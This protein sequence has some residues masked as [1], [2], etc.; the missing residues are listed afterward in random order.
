M[1]VKSEAGIKIHIVN[2]PLLGT[3]SAPLSVCLEYV[4]STV[5]TARAQF[6]CDQCEK[7]LSN[8]RQLLKCHIITNRNRRR[9]HHITSCQ[10]QCEKV[11]IRTNRYLSRLC[12]CQSHHHFIVILISFKTP[13]ETTAAETLL[14]FQVCLLS[15]SQHQL[16]H[17]DIFLGR[18][19]Q[20]SS[21]VHKF[22]SSLTGSVCRKL[23]WEWNI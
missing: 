23:V 15:L 18:V 2:C 9:C 6:Q 5:I 12:R 20:T 22:T 1:F 10:L 3:L 21:Q 13:S 4:S 14:S 19:T 17:E 16:E 11:Y 7:C 8:R